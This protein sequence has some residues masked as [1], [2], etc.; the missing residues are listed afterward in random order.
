M[1]PY[2]V[3]PG[4]IPS[5]LPQPFSLST[6]VDVDDRE[7]STMYGAGLARSAYSTIWPLVKATRSYSSSMENYLFLATLTYISD[8]NI[9]AL[10]N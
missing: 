6:M 8:G 7:Y 4:L 2:F 1:S 10:K 9:S 5:C 3:A